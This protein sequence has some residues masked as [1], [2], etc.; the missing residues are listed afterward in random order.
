MI[1]DTDTL[2][3]VADT[4][5]ERSARR[6]AEQPEELARYAQ[7]RQAELIARRARARARVRRRRALAGGTGIAAAVAAAV[8][9]TIGGAG[10]T[11]AGSDRAASIPP[12]AASRSSSGTPVAYQQGA[13]VTSLQRD[14]DQLGYYQGPIDGI[15]GPETTAAVQ[16]FQAANG[17]TVDGI[18]GPQTLAA[19][20]QVIAS[21]GNET[22]PSPPASAP[23]ANPTPA[24]RPKT[25]NLAP[26]TPA[27]PPA[28]GGA[29][30]S[31]AS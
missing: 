31:T 20:Q 3:L 29:S 16:A 11:G 6:R 24:A 1:A 10:E 13:W 7:E 15:L 18:A 14:L 21:A 5:A 8:V 28:T 17:L 4:F 19:L 2:E 23:A 9:L 26:L 27:T 30:T 22:V 25:V 12:A